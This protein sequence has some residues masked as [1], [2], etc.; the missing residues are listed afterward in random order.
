[1]RSSEK[2]GQIETANRCRRDSFA[3]V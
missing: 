3:E 1:M 2:I